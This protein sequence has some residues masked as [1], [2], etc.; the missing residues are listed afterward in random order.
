MHGLIGH[1]W[2]DWACMDW[3]GMHGLIGHA[4]ID[5][6]CMD[7]LGMHGLIGHAWIDWACLDWLGMPGLIGH[8]CMNWL[9]VA[10]SSCVSYSSVILLARIPQIKSQIS[11]A[12]LN[13]EGSIRKFVLTFALHLNDLMRM[14]SP[15]GFSDVDNSCHIPRHLSLTVSI[16]RCQLQMTWQVYSWHEI[17]RYFHR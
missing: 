6:A 9:V 11:I 13:R 12:W 7:W 1:A 16:Y 2:I 8:A 3:L 17:D 5:W 15:A 4:W 14:T 10:A